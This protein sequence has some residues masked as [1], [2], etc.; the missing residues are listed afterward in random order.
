MHTPPPSQQQQVIQVAARAFGISDT[1]VHIAE[2]ATDRV[3]TWG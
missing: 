2:T 1:Q 3:R